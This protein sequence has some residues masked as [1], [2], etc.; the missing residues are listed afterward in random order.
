MLGQLGYR[1][2]VVANGLEAVAA[3]RV[4][5]YDL[6][7]M[8]VQM[9]EMDGFEA[10][11]RDPPRRWRA[12]QRPRIVA[13]T[14]NAMQGDRERCLAAGMDDY[15]SKPIRM[16]ELVAALER[17]RRAGAGPG[18]AQPGRAGEPAAS[19][20]AA[21][22]RAS[23][24]RFCLDPA[25]VERLRGDDGRR[26]SSPT[27]CWTTF[28]DD[29]RELVVTRCAVPSARRTWTRSGGRRTRSSPP[30]RRSA[31]RGWRRS[32]ASSKPR[33][34]A[35]ASTGSAAG[36]TELVGEYER[37]STRAGRTAT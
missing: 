8:D 29:A 6:V 11:A 7:L 9:P 20:G 4:R 1:A 18:S 22:D 10:T 19:Q 34:A 25:A 28:V 30:A 21:V 3:V 33:P 27:S 15:V 14:A 26:L 12:D 16:E 36:S 24:R 31:P 2:D 23:R 13:M 17:Q 32:P 37:A 5:P 35:E